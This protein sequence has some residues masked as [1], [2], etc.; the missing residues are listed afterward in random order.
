MH[1]ESRSIDLYGATHVGRARREN[2]D[3]FLTCSLG[4]TLRIWGT[5]VVE[6]PQ[7]W[8]ETEEGEPSAADT[9]V[10]AVADGVGGGPG[11]ERASRWAV[12]R[13]PD[14]LQAALTRDG[15]AEELSAQLVSAIQG[16]HVDVNEHARAVLGLRGMAT[17]LTLWLGLGSRAFLVQVGDSRCYRLRDGELCQLSQDQT[18]AQDLVD[19]GVVASTDQAPAGWD[20]ILTSAL[21]GTAA[22][23]V[24]GITDRKPGDRTLV[25]SDGVMKHVSDEEIRDILASERN[26]R[27]MV[28]EFLQRALAGGGSDNI[29]AVV[30]R[31]PT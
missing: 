12:V 23:P 1:T 19:R 2:Q 8:P 25:C 26:A 17:T 21:G 18:M 10:A 31:E 6:R 5:S 7:S 28:D 22:A 20:N 27:E 29:T 30:V 4:S 15:D 3:H 24:V 14:H 13:L 9:L 16:L 11:G